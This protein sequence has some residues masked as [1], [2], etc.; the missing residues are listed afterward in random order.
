MLKQARVP[1]AVL[2]AC[3]SGAISRDL[4]AA[5][6]TRLLQ[7]G[8]ASVV[9]MAYTVYA[10]AAAEFMA[11]FYEL[12]FGG[13]PVSAAVAAGRRRMFVADR[14]PSP[15]GDMPLADWLIPVH[16][17]RRDVSFPQARTERSGMPSL[18]EALDQ[19]RAAKEGDGSGDLDPVGVFTGRDALFYELEAAARLRRV[20]L[21][22]G[23]GGAGKTELAKAFGRWWRDTGGV[24]Q[25]G[26]VFFHSFE[27]GPATFGLDGVVNEIGRRVFGTEFDRLEPAERRTVVEKVLMEH[28]ALLIWDNFE[29][30]HSM[31]AGKMPVPGDLKD[32]LARLGARG[33]SAVLIT[34]RSHEPWLGEIRRVQVGGLNPREADE[35]ASYLLDP[36]PATR[37]RRAVRAFGELLEWLDGHPLSMRLILPHLD[38]TE[39]SALLDTLRCA[40]PMIGE[41]EDGGR[42]TSLPAS[43]AYSYAHLSG[44]ARRLLPAVCLLQRVADL[45]VLGILS[46]VPSVPERFRNAE[47]E[48]WRR[49]LENAVGV[50]LLTSLGGGTYR[51]HPALPAY[52]A[53]RWRQDDPDGHDATREAATGAL[54]T[55]YAVFGVSLY[56]QIGSGNAGPA[57]AVTGLH[58]RTMGHMLGQ[59][60]ARQLWDEAQAIIRPLYSYWDARGLAEEA[61]AWT[62]QVLFATGDADGT[63]PHM[64]TPAGS[65]WLFTAGE[66]AGRQ[67]DRLRLDDARL[68]Y[69]RVRVMLEAQPPSTEQKHNLAVGYDRL[70]MVALRQGRL[71]EAAQWWRRSLAIGEEL[72]DRQVAAFAYHQLGMIAQEGER[73]G[74]AAEW[75]RKSLAISEKLGRR[76]YI[77]SAY[78]QLGMIAQEE[79]RLGEAAEWYHKSLAAK[80]DLGDRP[81]MA[82]TYHQLGIAAQ[83]GGRLGEAE[84]WYRKS[85]VIEEH[86]GDRLGIARS[87]HQLGIVA[88][89]GGRLVEAEEWYRKS[90]A[91]SEELGIRQGMALAFDQLGLLAEQRGD[92]RQAL[93]WAV[94]CI[95]VFG[96]VPHPLTGT[97]PRDL[98]RF[99]AALGIGALE[100]TWRRVTGEALPENVREYVSREG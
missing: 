63:V 64:D 49:V 14:R 97:G 53:A 100:E 40:A 27:P 29:S 11:A 72:G 8:T 2:N 56:Q 82:A 89:A 85:L 88:R 66:Q 28:R 80:E 35:Y 61:G 51:L 44:P 96:E 81:G 36:Y 99:T 13:E 15:K 48:D 4:G 5:V 54:I 75:Y 57:L 79:G 34:S 43:I 31:L 77:A 12:L 73:L 25:P 7:E 86:L 30:V 95:A 74:E 52:L 71:E 19:I 42:L 32:F 1:V 39:P 26:L 10:V 84:E 65:L 67:L 17:L 46:R 62:D 70:S 91:I 94:R 58:R 22:H 76:F 16:Y 55:A 90:L 41:D 38:T 59:A 98:A 68:A 83:R 87:F 45:D 23:P 60:L 24:E 3:Q 21:L 78:H 20:V 18:G 37:P 69:D 6:A 47:K 33:R 92:V 93:T 50:G 9:A